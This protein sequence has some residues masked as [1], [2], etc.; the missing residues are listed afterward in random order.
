MN[1]F[2]CRIVTLLFSEQVKEPLVQSLYWVL[3]NVEAIDS[4]KSV[5]IA[6]QDLL[7]IYITNITTCGTRLAT[8][9]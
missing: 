6:F 4:K 3:A 9:L 8:G 2:D 5:A 7:P 1:A